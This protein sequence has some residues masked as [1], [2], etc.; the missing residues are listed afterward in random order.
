MN[1]GNGAFRVRGDGFQEGGDTVYTLG[2]GSVTD[3]NVSGGP[4]V[5]YLFAHEN[6]GVDLN[7]PVHGFGQFTMTTAGGSSAPVSTNS[8]YPGLGDLRDIAFDGTD[9]WLARQSGELRRIDLATGATLA[10][11]SLPPG[12]ALQRCWSAGCSCG[13]HAGECHGA[14][15]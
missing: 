1:G 2:N 4:D 6:D 15:R 10:T 9:L 14:C 11:F 12:G 3:T 8:L 13:V 7:L 5:R